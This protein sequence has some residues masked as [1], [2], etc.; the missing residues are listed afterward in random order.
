M[1]DAQARY[2]ATLRKWANY[3]RALAEGVPVDVD[4][5]EITA[6]IDFNTGDFVRLDFAEYLS[7]RDELII[8][9]PERLEMLDEL[10]RQ[11]REAWD[12]AQFFDMDEASATRLANALDVE[13]ECVERAYL[14]E[15][16]GEGKSTDREAT[17]DL[18][19]DLA[20]E[21]KKG[22]AIQYCARLVCHVWNTG[23]HGGKRKSADYVFVK[24]KDGESLFVD[25]RYARRLV[26]KWGISTGGIMT[27]AAT[28]HALQSGGKHVKADGMER[29]ETMCEAA[30]K[31]REAERAERERKTEHG[32]RRS[33]KKR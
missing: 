1:T 6:A 20:P 17:P 12:L 21:S 19:K 26:E 14:P 18:L 23:E 13:A 24:A 28:I 7:F 32:A 10:R 5:A 11:T 15:A 16:G 25:C 22:D 8:N 33:G 3:A 31:S 2:S 30:R 9:R 27:K 4:A 29:P